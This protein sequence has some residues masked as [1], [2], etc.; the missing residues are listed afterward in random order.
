MQK[1]TEPNQRNS[2]LKQA[3][4]ALK[5]TQA[6]LQALERARTEPIAVIGVGCRIPGGC[7]SP[8]DYWR[9]LRNG[10]DAIAEA[11]RERWDV[12][13]YFDPDPDA[14]GKMYTRCGAVLV[15]RGPVRP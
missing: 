1:T 9:L 8:E 11:P 7:N 2:P 6:K 14:P 3:L 15:G 5:K 4:L 12:D 10:V 13:E